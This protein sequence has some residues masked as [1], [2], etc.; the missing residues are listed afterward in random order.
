MSTHRLRVTFASPEHA[1]S[2]LKLLAALAEASLETSSE[3]ATEF[4]VLEI[5]AA[6]AN[7]ERVTTLMRG[8]HPVVGASTLTSADIA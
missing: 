3:V 2:A 5:D 4:M 6:V 7:R 1:R 8:A